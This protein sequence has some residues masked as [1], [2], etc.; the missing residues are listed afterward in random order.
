MQSAR[1]KCLILYY[2]GLAAATKPRR[3]GCAVSP[4]TDWA[5]HLVAGRG[6]DWIS[7]GVGDRGG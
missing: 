6:H 5:S 3:L 2:R 7:L 4:R 1:R